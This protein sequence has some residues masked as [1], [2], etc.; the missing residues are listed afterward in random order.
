MHRSQPP[1][2][3]SKTLESKH[4]SSYIQHL[5][6]EEDGGGS[7]VNRLSRVFEAT[8]HLEKTKPV[9]PSKPPSLRP[10]RIEQEEVID[11]TPIAFKDIRARFQ[12]ENTIPI[13]QVIRLYS[14]VVFILI[15]FIAIL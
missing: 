11:H 1:D 2:A 3:F 8:T 4:R 15:S 9:P 6:H 13:K 10:K 14:E 7:T 12:Q 5:Q